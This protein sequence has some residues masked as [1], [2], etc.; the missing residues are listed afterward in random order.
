MWFTGVQVGCAACVARLLWC[1]TLYVFCSGSV[2][3]FV[4]GHGL[5]RL[6]FVV[7]FVVFGVS[8]VLV[9][10]LISNL[11]FGVDVLLQ[12]GV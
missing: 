6:P 10:F 12:V 3:W 4:C 11:V 7:R 1:R 2:W 9:C 8:C 5:V